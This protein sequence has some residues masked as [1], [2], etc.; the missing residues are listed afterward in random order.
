MKIEHF[1]AVI[2]T[3]T[4]NHDCDED[5]ISLNLTFDNNGTAV[6]KYIHYI[7]CHAIIVSSHSLVKGK[8]IQAFNVFYLQPTTK[9]VYL[10]KTKS[11]QIA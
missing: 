5:S 6:C 8:S 2:V 1:T 10:N 4:R 9:R 3:V 11:S 7:Q